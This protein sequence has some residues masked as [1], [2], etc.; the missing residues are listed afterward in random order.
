M[1]EEF[2]NEDS[3]TI[4]R[5]VTLLIA[6]GFIV[7]AILVLPW[8]N[9]PKKEEQ[10]DVKNP[11]NIVVEV[12][13]P[14]DNGVDVDTWIQDPAGEKVGYSN[15]S[16]T[17]FNLLRDDLGGSGDVTNLNY[18]H[19]F[20]RGIVPGKHIVNIHLFS[21]S[22]GRLPVTVRIVVSIKVSPGSVMQQF[23]AADITLTD[24][25]EEQTVVSFDITED[26][27]VDM[28]SISTIYEPLVSDNTSMFGGPPTGLR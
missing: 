18:E 4:F 9:P 6:A 20:S 10:E 7:L 21:Q 23:F 26:K 15:K 27:T 11:G 17:I 2:E 13:W 19:A 3:A 12:I 16:G 8:V 28:K 14:S 22:S 1:D 25:R 5:D 24:I